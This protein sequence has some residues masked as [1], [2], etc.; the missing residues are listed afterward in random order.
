MYLICIS[1]YDSGL[2]LCDI[3]LK[4]AMLLGGNDAVMGPANS[5]CALMYYSMYNERF[6]LI[7]FMIS[8]RVKQFRFF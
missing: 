5:S 6:D 4:T 2:Y 8:F 7:P 1:G 3:S